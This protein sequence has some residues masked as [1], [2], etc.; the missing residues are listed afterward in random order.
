MAPPG[1]QNRGNEE[2]DWGTGCESRGKFFKF[3]AQITIIE[4]LVS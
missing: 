1:M 3:I 2:F 4:T